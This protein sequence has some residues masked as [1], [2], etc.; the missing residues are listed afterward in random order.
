MTQIHS[1]LVRGGRS[2]VFPLDM[3]RYGEAYPAS[4]DDAALIQ[5]SL[6]GTLGESRGPV[7]VR[8]CSPIDITGYS[9]ARI[10]KR[11]ES[12]G[13]TVQVQ[14]PAGDWVPYSEQVAAQI[15]VAR[16]ERDHV[17]AVCL[18]TGLVPADA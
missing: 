18:G 2:N 6:E 16:F 11:W 13:W 12:F 8:L 17:D 3:L 1:F 7:F 9:F 15:G 5:K 4:T 14:E 10:V